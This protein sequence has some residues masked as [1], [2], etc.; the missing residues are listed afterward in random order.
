MMLLTKAIRKALPPLGT[1]TGQEAPIA[2]VKFFCPWGPATWFA[3]EFDGEDS[4]F[5]WAMLHPGC[6]ELGYF[7]LMELA[8]YRGPFGLGVERD[9]HFTPCPLSEAIAPHAARA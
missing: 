2:Q 4:F 5:G 9:L 8:C 6:G 1:T 3:T 7:S